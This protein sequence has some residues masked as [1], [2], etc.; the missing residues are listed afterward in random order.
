MGTR[1]CVRDA[2]S[3]LLPS[4]PR[5]RAADRTGCP[6]ALHGPGTPS[7]AAAPEAIRTVGGVHIWSSEAACGDDDG[8]S[9]D[10]WILTGN[11]GAGGEGPRKGRQRK[12]LP[13]VRSAHGVRGDG[14]VGPRTLRPCC[15]LHCSSL[16]TDLTS[17]AAG[18]LRFCL[19]RN[20]QHLCLPRP[21]VLPSLCFLRDRF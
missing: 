11:L 7:H 12:V 16:G 13:R 5:C 10:C 6:P 14:V 20:R 17:S 19:R 18:A 21:T 1:V 3:W 8:V 2:G 9:R 15:L 4:C